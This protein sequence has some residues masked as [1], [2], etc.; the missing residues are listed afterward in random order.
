MKVILLK[1][2]KKL[3]SKN[4]VKEVSV[5][6]AKNFLLK[7]GLAKIATKS[8]IKS[9]EKIKEKEEKEKE[10]ELEETKKTAKNIDNKEFEIKLK[11]GE[12]KELFESVTPTKISQKLEEEGFQVQKKQ[13]NL[14]KSIKS[15]GEYP[16]KIDFGEG[17]S[18]TVTIKITEE[19]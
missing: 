10:K 3:G 8:N 12:K 9:I 6:Y 4:E 14:E 19:K 5:G 2:I 15:L 11:V 16:V 17:I 1:D 18:A 7:Q 13:I